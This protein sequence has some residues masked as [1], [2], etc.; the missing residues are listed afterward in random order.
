[1]LAPVK[2]RFGISAE[3]GGRDKAYGSGEFLAWLLDR[4]MQPY[5][6]V[7]D[8]ADDFYIAAGRVPLVMTWFCWRRPRIYSTNSTR[9]EIPNFSYILKR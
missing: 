2:E 4:S 6:P 1:M 9:L 7:I 5:I 8:R 3:G